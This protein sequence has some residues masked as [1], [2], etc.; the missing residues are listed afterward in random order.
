MKEIFEIE[1]HEEMER[2]RIEVIERKYK[3][4]QY[5]D[6]SVNVIH[7]KREKYNI[8]KLKIIKKNFY[9]NWQKNH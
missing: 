1:T 4:F 9:Q 7:D 8:K 6:Y 3:I 5:I 2:E